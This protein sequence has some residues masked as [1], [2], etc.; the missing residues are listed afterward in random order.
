MGTL[1]TDA[2][3]SGRGI[4]LLVLVPCLKGL[5]ASLVGTLAT[6]QV[7]EA[8]RCAMALD[9]PRADLQDCVAR[10]AMTRPAAREARVVVQ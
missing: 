2:R 4:A 1:P 10:L 5:G 8:L 3:P 6:G 9:E 7:A